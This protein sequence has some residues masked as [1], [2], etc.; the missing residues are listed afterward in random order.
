MVLAFVA[1]LF[2]SGQYIPD[3]HL[4]RADGLPSN[5]VYH[6]LQDRNHYMWFATDRGVCRYDG[7]NF[8]YWTKEDGLPDNEVYALYEDYKGRIWCV[9]DNHLLGFIEGDS[10]RAYSY[11]SI[12]L[13]VLD[14]YQVKSAYNRFTLRV[15]ENDTLSIGIPDL[16]LLKLSPIGTPDIIVNRLNERSMSFFHEGKVHLS[17][18]DSSKHIVLFDPNESHS[19]RVV[20][21]IKGNSL[22]N[23]TSQKKYEENSIVWSIYSSNAFVFSLE[24]ERV[25]GFIEGSTEFTDLNV[26]DKFGILGS[27]DTGAKIVDK[28]S[29]ETLEKI[30]FEETVSGICVDHENNLWISYDNNGVL[31]FQGFASPLPGIHRNSSIRSIQRYRGQI[32]FIKNGTDILTV[33]GQTVYIPSEKN[34][35]DY[36]YHDGDYLYINNPGLSILQRKKVI[37]T[38]P[39]YYNLLLPFQDFFFGCN[40]KGLHKLSRKGEIIERIREGIKYG[41]NFRDGYIDADSTIYFA[42]SAGLGRFN[43][44]QNRYEQITSGTALYSFAEKNDTLWALADEDLL[45]LTGDT[46]VSIF[47][48]NKFE[49]RGCRK[50]EVWN[51]DFWIGSKYG[52]Y[53]I[54]KVSDSVEVMHMTTY[55]GLYSNVVNDIET[56][57]DTLFVATDKGLNT[58]YPEAINA[59]FIKPDLSILQVHIDGVPRYERAPFHLEYDENNIEVYFKRISYVLDRIQKYR[60]RMSGLDDWNYTSS[61]SARYSFV[62]PGD[63]EFQVELLD[64]HSNWVQRQRIGIHI[65]SPFW[66]TWWFYAAIVVLIIMITIIALLPFYRLRL[67]AIRK[68]AELSESLVKYRQLALSKQMNPHFIFNS[69]N[70]IQSFVLHQDEEKSSDFIA[71]FSRLMRKVL[72]LSENNLISIAD[73][74]DTLTEYIELE[75]MRFSG[76]F[77]YKIELE[78]PHLSTYLIPPMVLQPFVENAIWHGFER[79]RKNNNLKIELNEELSTLRCTISDN[80]MGRAKQKRDKGSYQPMGTS[81]TKKR[82][83]ELN[84]LYELNLSVEY[85]D[86]DPAAEGWTTIVTIVIPKIWTN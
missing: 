83:E 66:Q 26:L 29:L 79:N 67:R 49:L 69:L 44:D 31:F 81:L 32:E 78:N 12:I 74:I 71:R 57:G 86:L 23:I 37:A 7:E 24:K 20:E 38:L 34:T 18:D 77:E 4:T 65:A 56:Y 84:A 72:I 55:Q 15:M 54:R 64:E 2:V 68:Q 22:S 40:A 17:L 50:L 30:G 28:Y 45:Y 33:S 14:R 41:A 58:I 61:T 62:P 27:R 82:I 16:G 10:A 35:I 19:A 1:P 63:Y 76:K 39:G 85:T 6:L 9:T 48:D 11:N 47:R 70:S 73:E 42:T 46:L 8:K 5:T 43:N 25:H 80:G 51:G 13:D 59:S 53:R 75:K 21:S 36:F 3:R 52:L 60:Y